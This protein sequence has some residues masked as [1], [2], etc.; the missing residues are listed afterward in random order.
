MQF[1]SKQ[2]DLARATPFLERTISAKSPSP[3]LASVFIQADNGTVSL[4]ATDLEVSL[5][6][7]V[8]ADVAEP[9]QALLPARY[10]N[11]LVQSAPSNADITVR[12]AS[13]QDSTEISWNHSQYVLHGYNPQDFPKLPDPPTDNSFEV[14]QNGFRDLI[15]HVSFALAK[16]ESRPILT[17]AYLH[18]V[19][20]DLALAATDGYRVAFCSLPAAGLPEFV[21]MVVPGRALADLGRLLEQSDAPVAVHAAQNLVYVRGQNFDFSSRLIEGAFPNYRQVVPKEVV[22]RVV[23]D[24][25][26]LLVTC[27]RAAFMQAHDPVPVIRLSLGSDGLVAQFTT[28]EDHRGVER[29]LGSL[30]GSS[31]QVAFNARYLADALRQIEAAQ[32]EIELSGPISACRIRGYQQENFYVVMLPLRLQG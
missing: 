1:T 21:P 18:S 4:A 9:G 22:A 23:V 15:S 30:E 31:M 20:G 26:S 27:N 19:G 5:R 13:E 29:L 6:M 28:S 7:T 32:A 25:E 8:A 11:A 12:T 3:V 10:F 14:N 2:T 24:K 17:G 16:D